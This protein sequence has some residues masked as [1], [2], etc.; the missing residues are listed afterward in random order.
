MQNKMK[1]DEI[2]YS[3]NTDKEMGIEEE[4]TTH[5][6]KSGDDPANNNDVALP[7]A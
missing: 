4:K 1:F 2:Q 5:D 7:Y 3:T 6:F